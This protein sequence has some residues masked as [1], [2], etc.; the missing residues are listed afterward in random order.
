MAKII[1]LN[2][3]DLVRIV[4]RVINEEQK[5]EKNLNEGVLTNTKK[6]GV[7]LSKTK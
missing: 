5:N 7:N 1:K 6:S 2:E 4:K 3:S